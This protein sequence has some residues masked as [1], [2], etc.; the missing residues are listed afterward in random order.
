MVLFFN[1]EFSYRHKRTFSGHQHGLWVE[2]HCLLDSALIVD[3]NVWA[4]NWIVLRNDLL[5]TQTV[6]LPFSCFGSQLHILLQQLIQAKLAF[7]NRR[8][9]GGLD[10]R[11]IFKPGKNCYLFINNI[12]KRYYRIILLLVEDV[13]LAL[14]LGQFNLKLDTLLLVMIQQS[15]L[16]NSSV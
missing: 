1:R 9:A 14:Q 16:L 7:G 12:S 6:A 2:K 5:H 10:S 4:R 13:I 8:F 3:R 15:Q 11:K